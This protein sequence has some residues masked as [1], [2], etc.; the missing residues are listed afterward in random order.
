MR[1]ASKQLVEASGA[2]KRDQLVATA[3]VRLPDDDLRHGG[4]LGAEAL[5]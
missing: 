3:N 5:D 2:F 1:S 4:V